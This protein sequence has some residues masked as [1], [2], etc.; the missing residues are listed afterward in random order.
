MDT[1]GESGE[2]GAVKLGFLIA[3]DPEPHEPDSAA[4]AARVSVSWKRGF[5][6]VLFES[7]YGMVRRKLVL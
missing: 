5:D 3:L 7:F 2:G 4:T 1:G 6:G